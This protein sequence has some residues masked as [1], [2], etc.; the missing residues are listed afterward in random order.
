MTFK[1]A[2]TYT[3][4]VFVKAFDGGAE[5]CAVEKTVSVA[6]ANP[7][8]ITT[9]LADQNYTVS[10]E[11]IDMAGLGWV[12]LKDYA[13]IFDFN[14][15][16]VKNA[17]FPMFTSVLGGTVKN[18][19]LADSTQVY[20]N[21]EAEA[22]KDLI[23]IGTAATTHCQVY[24]GV[25]RYM[26]DGIISNITIESTVNIT[27]DIWLNDSYVGGVVG[28]AKGTNVRVEDCTFK[29]TVTTD[30]SKIFI[31]GIA[32]C[33]QGTDTAAHVAD[34]PASSTVIAINCVNYGS[35]NDIAVGND[36]KV[37]GV[38]GALG[39]GAAYKC[40]N[41]GSVTGSDK[42][43]VAGVVGHTLGSLTYMYC[44]NTGDI[45]GGTGYTGGI[46]GYS[47]GTVRNIIGCINL[48]T[49]GLAEGVNSSNLGGICG[50]IR[51]SENF[52]NCY[53]LKTAYADWGYSLNPVDVTDPS[54][55]PG[56]KGTP[57]ITDCG[58]LDTVDAIL[59]A[60]EA[61]HP[62]IYEKN[63]DSLKLVGQ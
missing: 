50:K 52:V 43:Q 17:M 22:D 11:T 46:T 7:A 51:N 41:H 28:L 10:A 20:T 19:V 47:N 3:V 18:L 53:N 54:T 12:G 60:I 55:W 42:G 62:G 36:S 9:T 13:A 48:G 27:A 29:G 40:A 35:V 23:V 34:D 1:T 31:G 16:T 21:D 49:I 24:G 30:S 58:N 39:S 38:V 44:L 59:A 8:A 4:K 57:T 15:C 63:G 61:T 56:D 6:K 45:R 5:L 14:G 25:I 2:G 37:G 33:V 32:G 26:N